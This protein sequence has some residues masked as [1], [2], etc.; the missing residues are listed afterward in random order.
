[1]KD[2]IPT[3]EDIELLIAA[4]ASHE[5]NLVNELVVDALLKNMGDLTNEEAFMQAFSHT[6]EKELADKLKGEAT[7]IR[8]RMVI[9]GAKLINFRDAIRQQQVTG[10]IDH[11]L[12]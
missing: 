8:D 5:K 11:L 9:L 12:N 4:L 2:Y 7:K 3:E 1:M 6:D 10:E